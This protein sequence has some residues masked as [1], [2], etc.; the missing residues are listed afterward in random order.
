M[1][2]YKY[3]FGFLFKFFNVFDSSVFFGNSFLSRTLFYFDLP[4]LASIKAFIQI[5]LG[6]DKTVC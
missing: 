2:V 5:I 4:I 6:L 1:I 3:N